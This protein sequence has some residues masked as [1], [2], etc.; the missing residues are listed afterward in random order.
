[1]LISDLEADRTLLLIG[2]IAGA[3]AG[4]VVSGDGY[5]VLGEIADNQFA[6]STCRRGG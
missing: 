4:R 5:R 3:P 6:R 2:L 1:M